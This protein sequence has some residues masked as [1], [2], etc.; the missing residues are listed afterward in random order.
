MGRTNPTFR[1]FLDSYE[2]RW[3]P[4][5]R[6]LRRRH[7]EDFDRLFDRARSHA[8]AAGHANATDPGT[9]VLLS[10]LLAQER[11]LRDLRERLEAVEGDSEPVEGDSET[12]ET[13]A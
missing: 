9:A 7:R 2:D 13:D 10:M 11:E 12:I 3:R 5:R 8:D 6:A 1:D 4:F